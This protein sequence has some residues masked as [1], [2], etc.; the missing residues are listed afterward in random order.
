MFERLKLLFQKE[1]V[2]E[3]PLKPVII[4]IHGYGRRRKHEFDNFALWGSKDHYEIIQFDMYDLFDETDNDWMMWVSRAK[5]TVNTYQN[6]GRDIYL[7]GFSMGGVIASYLAATCDIKK[8]VLLAPAFSYM[9]MDTIAGAIS[10][11]YSSF[12]SKSSE[13]KDEIELPKS[14]YMA[15]MDLVK[16]LKKYIAQ[17][18]CPTLML[19]GD[20]DEVI[21]VRSST[22]A[23]HKIPHKNKKLVILHEGH[24][25]L[26]MDK[27]VHWE[28][29][30]WIK[31]FF[32][33][34]ILN[35]KEIE[36]AP[37]I[38]DTLLQRYHELHAQPACEE[39]HE[40]PERKG[41]VHASNL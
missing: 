16:N 3:Q 22:S 40:E 18:P 20:E 39:K 37:D 9:N 32:E 17:V 26:F 36:L 13:K 38:I 10:K 25:R 33:D 2:Q 34:I 23:Y 21:S 12:L 5:D 29:Y 19:H 7:V 28:C 27:T 11:S 24:H 35:E 8:L 1:T 30:Q 6:Q 41:E 31:L 4:T 14:F 15:F